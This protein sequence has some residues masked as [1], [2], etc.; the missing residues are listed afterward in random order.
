MIVSVCVD[1][2]CPHMYEPTHT[3]YSVSGTVGGFCEGFLNNDELFARHTQMRTKEC[4]I[5]GCRGRGWGSTLKDACEH[6]H[7]LQTELLRLLQRK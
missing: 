4:M 3:R 1:H 6:Y 2:K 5:A 7:V